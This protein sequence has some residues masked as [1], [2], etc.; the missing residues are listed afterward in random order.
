MV[1]LLLFVCSLNCDPEEDFTAIDG[2]VMKYLSTLTTGQRKSFMLQLHV[3]QICL[4]TFF[5]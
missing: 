3:I 4:Y 5:K 1:S 2:I